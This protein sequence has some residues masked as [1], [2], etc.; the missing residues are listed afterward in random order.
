MLI[1]LDDV[2]FPPARAWTWVKDFDEFFNLMMETAPEDVEVASLD[3]DLA[4][5]HYPWSEVSPGAWTAKCG[6]DV[7]HA[8]I[9]VKFFPAQVILHSMN[10]AGVKNMRDALTTEG[11]SVVGRAKVPYANQAAPV[12]ERRS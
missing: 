9:G 11:Y 5:E 10:P 2:R 8:M 1:W 6:L 12:L 3:H 4:P 7:V